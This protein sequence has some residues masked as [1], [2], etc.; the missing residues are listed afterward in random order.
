MAGWS[1]WGSLLA[2]VGAIGVTLALPFAANA[3][4][5]A[6]DVMLNVLQ[7]GFALAAAAFLLGIGCH[8]VEGRLARRGPDQR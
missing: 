8:L 2:L 3:S 5:D 1:F 4:G 7:A 6:G